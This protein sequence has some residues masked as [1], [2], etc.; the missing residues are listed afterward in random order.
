[1][2]LQNLADEEI[3]LDGMAWRERQ[4]GETGNLSISNAQVT[5]EGA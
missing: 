3:T 4:E 5:D 1:M 2:R